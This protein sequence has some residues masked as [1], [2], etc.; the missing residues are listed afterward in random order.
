MADD[1]LGILNRASFDV[2][3][4]VVQQE[5][6][7][8]RNPFG[9]PQE[10]PRQSSDQWIPFINDNSGTCPAFAIM[11]VV[12]GLYV[13]TNTASR[14]IH[15]DQ[16][17]T[18][19]A[20]LYAVNAGQDVPTGG[21][22]LCCLHGPCD[23]LYDT[24]TPASEE[25]WGPKPSQWSLSKGYPRT[26]TV[27]GIVD[28]SDKILH[29][30]FGAITS[31]LGKA[32]GAITARSGTTPGTGNME[33]WCN[34]AGTLTDAG[35]ADIT[36]KNLLDTSAA[37]GAYVEA[38][39]I[40]NDWLLLPHA[41][42]IWHVTLASSLA[43]GASTT[44][45]LS[46]GRSVSATNYS[47]VTI[48][49]G[50]AIAVEDL[51][52]STIYLTA[53]GT[54]TNNSTIH[55]GTA[56]DI[57]QPAGT[58]TITLLD[59]STVEAV[60]QSPIS[61][62]SDPGD[63][64]SVYQDD[65]IWY[66][67]PAGTQVFNLTCP[68]PGVAAGASIDVVIPDGRTVS[69]NNYSRTKI[70]TD[71]KIHVYLNRHTNGWRILHTDD[72]LRRRVKGLINMAA[73]LKGS[74]ANATVDNISTLDGDAAPSITTAVNTLKLWGADNDIVILEEETYTGAASTWW[75]AS[76]QPAA[77]VCR[78][79]KCLLNGAL[80]N[81][82][83]NATIDTVTAIDGGSA[84]APTSAVNYLGWAGADNDPCFIIEDWS[85]GSVAYILEAV[86]WS[87]QTVVTDSLIDAANTKLQKKT[88]S[89]LGKGNAAESGATD[90]DTGTT[91]T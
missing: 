44:V 11:R 60:N 49:A 52:N 21:G 40:G 89:M 7:R 10:A 51:T 64:I 23:I 58:G 81:A 20:T 27:L 86:K 70:F 69:C 31:L 33:I 88:R 90:I 63:K 34:L 91:C 41:N 71:S 78:K 15:C 83:A 30:T 36:V 73:G 8:V 6:A 26:T 13:E 5:L 16:P 28:S 82:D 75:V 43:D 35:F 25:G 50:H 59:L 48:S 79:F 4:R 18:T 76:I 12:T 24:G 68:S 62:F 55:P 45:T 46:D 32:N 19:L 22:G 65:S 1:E 61:V 56:A 39:L 3:K 67:I 66:A 14:L 85:S 77:R 17:S 54:V 29:G 80:A 74:D 72:F 84:P 53:G 9:S 57:I 47:G 42:F 37:S 2:I 87:L 38:T